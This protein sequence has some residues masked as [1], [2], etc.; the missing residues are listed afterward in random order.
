MD[1]HQVDVVE[2]ELRQVLERGRASVFL[3]LDLGD[4]EEFVAVQAAGL[5]RVADAALRVVVRRGV[6]HAKAE[7][8]G[9]AESFDGVRR[10]VPGAESEQRHTIA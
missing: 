8:E 2:L 4:D 1:Q 5:D 3:G 6:D 10:Q 9:F 7:F